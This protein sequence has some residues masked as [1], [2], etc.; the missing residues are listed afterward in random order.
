[1]TRCKLHLNR[2][3]IAILVHGAFPRR[4]IATYKRRMFGRHTPGGTHP[5]SCCFLCD[6]RSFTAVSFLRRHA[7]CT[8]LK[9]GERD[10]FLSRRR[11]LERS[12]YVRWHKLACG[13]RSEKPKMSSPFGQVVRTP[14]SKR[15]IASRAQACAVGDLG[16]SRM[17]ARAVAVNDGLM[18][19]THSDGHVGHATDI[20][21][22][23]AA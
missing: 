18:F 16:G 23:A 4:N 9:G 21:S 13:R 5:F 20:H 15:I 17:H 3:G 8:S 19:L 14:L 6:A 2:R 22:A 11:V 10:P 12:L 7:R 1:M